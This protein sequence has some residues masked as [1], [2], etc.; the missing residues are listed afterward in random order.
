MN[1]GKT[2]MKDFLRAIPNFFTFIKNEGFITDDDWKE[3]K[4]YNYDW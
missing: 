2:V 1:P 3:I 4:E